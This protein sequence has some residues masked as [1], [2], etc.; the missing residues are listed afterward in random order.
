MNLLLKNKYIYI[1]FLIVLS[2]YIYP[3]IVF[4]EIIINPHD[5]LEI[6][7]VYSY[8]TSQIYKG[9][10]DSINHFL[11]GEIKWYYLE[12]L[13][14]P[15]NILNTFLSDKIFFFTETILQKVLAYFSFYLLAKSIKIPKFESSLGALIYTSIIAIYSASSFF[16][17]IM[18]YILYLLVS[19]VH[20]KIKHYIIIILIGLNSSLAQDIF[21]LFLIIPFSYFF[22]RKNKS[23]NHGLKIFFTIFL[24]ILLVNLH[25]IFATLLSDVV[26]HRENFI[27]RESFLVSSLETVKEIFLIINIHDISFFFLIPLGLLYVTIILASVATREKKIKNI[28]YFF[29][30]ILFLLTLGGSTLIE[31]FFIGPLDIFSSINFRRINRV[32]PL[33]MTMLLIY[34]ILNIKKSSI[35][36]FI[37]SLSIIT[38]LS[39]QL[40]IPVKETIRSFIKPN[41][42]IELK[43]FFLDYNFVNVPHIL[44]HSN[45]YFT[46][47]DDEKYRTNKTFDKYYQFDD[48]K[49]I[50]KIVKESRVLSVDLDPMVAVMNNIKVIDGYHN[51]YPNDYK[52]KFRKIISKELDNNIKLK[53]YYDDWGNRVYAFYTDKNN[54]LLD[55]LAAKEIGADYVISSFAITNENLKIICS[56]CNNSKK[57][58]LYKIL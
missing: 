44:F 1:F 41:A 37:Y 5:K 34:N 29:I 10:F 3:L 15:I 12:R 20:L 22:T 47:N 24:S 19:R 4:N 8:I 17:F 57:L 28:L 13:F 50:K 51:I 43:T 55:F 35:K 52:L 11:S 18:P 21:S 16:I 40:M 6:D 36:I 2:H 27:I 31:F 45:N 53:N 56:K 33:F 14:F 26:T 25:L 42:I 58:F 23:F 54:L 49:F 9:N 48:Y 32:I 39:L 7:T 30:F 46:K 38:A